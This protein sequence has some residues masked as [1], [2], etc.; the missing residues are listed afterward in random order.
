MQKRK[1][2]IAE[3]KKKKIFSGLP[4]YETVADIANELGLS[5]TMRLILY[6]FRWRMHKDNLEAWPSQETMAK[7]VGVSE[8]SIRENIRKLCDLNLIRKR[9]CKSNRYS[10]I[11]PWRIS[12]QPEVQA[13][14][15]EP[16]VQASGLEPEVPR[17]EPEVSRKEPEVQASSKL[18]REYKKENTSLQLKGEEEKVIPFSTASH[19]KKFYKVF[20]EN[21]KPVNLLKTS[22]ISLADI[23]APFK[24]GHKVRIKIIDSVVFDQWKEF[25][26]KVLSR[27]WNRHADPPGKGFHILFDS[28][29]YS[30]LAG[31]FGFQP[32]SAGEIQAEA[33]ERKRRELEARK[34]RK[35]EE[36]EAQKE[37]EQESR[38]KQFIYKKNVGEYFQERGLVEFVNGYQCKFNLGE[39][40]SHIR[41]IMKKNNITKMSELEEF[42]KKEYQLIIQHRNEKQG[43]KILRSELLKSS[44]LR[45]AFYSKG[46][47]KTK[48][49][50][51]LMFNS[52]SS[53]RL[54]A[55]E[56]V[57]AGIDFFGENGRA[58]IKSD[59]L[60]NHLNAFC[61]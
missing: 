24:N 16:E 41:Q 13:S 19:Q 14:A 6:N 46:V 56:M 44:E 43:V 61:N 53:L 22:D 8:R 37:R 33:S 52:D 7:I 47:L 60:F 57:K 29:L 28:L 17:K 55:R 45:K 30:D 18:K 35:I 51:D 10:F 5:G 15:L 27:H 1:S 25:K 49:E 39:I 40:K 32:K 58:Q 31:F 34:R 50:A 54:F 2:T 3:V 36:A 48:D 21:F 11:Y 9:R 4:T 23:I 20:G 59:I 42:C 12:V 38:L 26:L